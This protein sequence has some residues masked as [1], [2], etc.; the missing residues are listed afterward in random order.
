[1]PPRP[2][3]GRI[4]EKSLPPGLFPGIFIYP[5][6]VFSDTTSEVVVFIGNLSETGGLREARVEE[7]DPKLVASHPNLPLNLMRPLT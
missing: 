6:R 3:C 1:M 4:T 2:F 7:P 5:G